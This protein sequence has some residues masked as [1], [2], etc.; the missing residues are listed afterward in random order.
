MTTV[1]GGA[2]AINAQASDESARKLRWFGIDRGSS[3]TEQ[4]VSS[5]GY[6]YNMNNVTATIGLVQLRF[7]QDIIDEHIDHGKYFDEEL[8]KIPGI[9]VAQFDELAEPSYWMYTVLAE[10][11][12]DRDDLSTKLTEAGIANGLVH[13]RNDLHDVFADSKCY[14]PGLD[15]FYS[16]MLHIPCG[17]WVT[18]EDREYV[19]RI[20]GGG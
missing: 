10:T 19:V 18:D 13:R 6:K 14:L 7:I 4:N 16:H 9:S 20:I 5:V 8:P 17:W 1:D 12:A 11:E 2:L 3:R 15:W